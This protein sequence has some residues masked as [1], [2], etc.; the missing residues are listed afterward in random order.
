MRITAQEQALARA[1]CKANEIAP[2]QHRPPGITEPPNWIF[3]IQD[4]RNAIT[5]HKFF[6]TSSRELGGEQR[7]PIE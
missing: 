5:A 7:R 2:D 4:A 6:S 3:F 1:M